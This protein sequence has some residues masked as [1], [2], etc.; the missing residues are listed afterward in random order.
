MFP[1]VF[2]RNNIFKHT[3]KVQTFISLVKI[4]IKLVQGAVSAV[5]SEVTLKAVMAV[6]RQACD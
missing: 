4:W 5:L 3:L 2:C 1:T 6:W